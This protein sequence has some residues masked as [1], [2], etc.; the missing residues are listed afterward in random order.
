LMEKTFKVNSPTY[1]VHEQ[2]LISSFLV[3]APDTSY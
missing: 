1:N 3:A 2:D